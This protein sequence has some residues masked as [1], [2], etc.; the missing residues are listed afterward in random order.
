VVFP[1]ESHKG[2]HAEDTGD[3]SFVLLP[4]R[5]EDFR[6]SLEEVNGYTFAGDFQRAGDLIELV[7]GF[8]V[9]D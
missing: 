2:I 9:Y 5:C 8:S 6:I 3:A 4:T 1:Q 7:K